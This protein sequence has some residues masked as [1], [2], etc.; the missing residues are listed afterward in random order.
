MKH[1]FIGVNKPRCVRNPA[2]Q[3]LTHVAEAGREGTGFNTFSKKKA[4][5]ISNRGETAADH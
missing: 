3:H 1:S 5:S 2:A 4:Q